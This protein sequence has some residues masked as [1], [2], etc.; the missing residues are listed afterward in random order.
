[1]FTSDPFVNREGIAVDDI[2]I[3]DNIYGIY[4]GP[5]HQ[6]CDQS[7]TV[8]GNAWIDFTDGGKLIASV[9]PNGRDPA[10]LM[11]GHYLSRCSAYK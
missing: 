9:N 8:T 6:Q 3:Y 5:P 11:Q 10:V 7:T 4:N 2:H 1:V